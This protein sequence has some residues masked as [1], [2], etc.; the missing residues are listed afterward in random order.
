MAPKPIQVCVCVCVCVC[1]FQCM[2]MCMRVCPGAAHRLKPWPGFGSKRLTIFGSC[3]RTSNTEEGL[4]GVAQVATQRKPP[5]R[6]A[7]LYDPAHNEQVSVPAALPKRNKIG[8]SVLTLSSDRHT[9]RQTDRYKDIQTNLMLKN[10]KRRVISLV[11]V[12]F[13]LYFIRK[14]RQPCRNNK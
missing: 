11:V 9:D 3:L 5:L 13:G 8:V 2:C 1:V 4:P 6:H 7:F 12:G 14:P 10:T